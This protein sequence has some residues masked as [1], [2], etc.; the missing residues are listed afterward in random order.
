MVDSAFLSVIVAADHAIIWYF[1]VVN[2][3]YA[4]LLILSVPEI[5]RNWNVNKSDDLRRYVGSKALPPIS[6]IIPAYDMEASITDSVDAQLQLTYPQHEV[7]V[8]NDGSRDST[9]ERLRKF[10]DL[11]EVPPAFPIRIPT[12]HV[13]GYYRSRT[14]PALLIVDKENGGKADALNVGISAARY[15]LVVAV[16]ADTIV[17]RDALLRL[18]RPFLLGE[19][20]AAAGGTIRVANGCELDHAHVVT[21]KVPRRFLPAVQVPEYLRA[22]LFGR[23]GWN[24]LG[25][26]VIIS[27]AFGLFQRDYLIAIGGYTRGSV[28]EDLDLVVRLHTYLKSKG[29]PYQIPFVPDPVAWTEVPSDLR[30]HRRQR[31]RWHRGLIVTLF[32]HIRLMF[33]PKYGR[34]GMITM[35]FFFFGEMLAPVVEIVGYVLTGL[36]LAFGVLSVE[37]ALLFLAVALGYQV[38]LSLCAIILEEVTFREYRRLS[39]FVRLIGYALLEPFGYRQITVLWRLKGFWNALRG[40]KHWGE[41]RRAGFQ[42]EPGG[43]VSPAP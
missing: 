6:V 21:P 14:R 33:N 18:A 32:T 22:F 4:S 35:P 13:R 10:F 17:A 7:I 15:P 16:D 19:N 5:W 2:T 31:E 29:I 41:M 20:V 8:V 30:T 11:Y 28:V 3:C 40:H 34:V 12:E 38:F 24:R 43:A 23:L 37:F 9:M 42:A 25:G 39:D 27:G 1:L 36:G 26:N